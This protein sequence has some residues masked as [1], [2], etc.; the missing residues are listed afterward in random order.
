MYQHKPSP[1][2]IW[3]VTYVAARQ[4]GTLSYLYR[5]NVELDAANASD[6]IRFMTAAIW[7]CGDITLHVT[8]A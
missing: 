1:L 4:I 6:A 3:H 5:G 2:P 8:A 7:Q